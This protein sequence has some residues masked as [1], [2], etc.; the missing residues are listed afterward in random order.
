MVN[1]T[2]MCAGHGEESKQLKS[3][4]DETARELKVYKKEYSALRAQLQSSTMKV[5]ERGREGEGTQGGSR[6]N[7]IL[8][9]F[10]PSHH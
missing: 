4:Q 5:R 3:L 10:F 6:G 9:Y 8:V 2:V 7:L 1:L